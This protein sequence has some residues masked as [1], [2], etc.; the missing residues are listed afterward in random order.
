MKTIKLLFIAISAGVVLLFGYA[1][2]RQRSAT[3]I[4]KPVNLISFQMQG[5]LNADARLTL[6]KKVRAVR[7]VTACSLNKEGNVASV[8]FHP[9]RITDIRLAGLLSDG[10]RLQV[11]PKE[12]PSAAGCPVQQLG[13]SLQ[14]FVT[15]LDNSKLT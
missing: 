1:N 6:E 14:K 9:D 3:E 15:S 8:T 13:A 12:I 11:L 5:D 4:L 2:V 10:G 7:G